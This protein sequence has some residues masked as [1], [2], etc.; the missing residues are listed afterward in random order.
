MRF[1]RLYYPLIYDWARSAGAGP[2][3]A[4]DLVQDVLTVLIRKMPGVRIR[5]VEDLPRLATHGHA[6]RLASAAAPCR[7]RL[8]IEAID[9]NEVDGEDDRRAARSRRTSTGGS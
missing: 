1:V 2:E 3:D 6:Q 4:A 7:R 5:F 9:L 8:P